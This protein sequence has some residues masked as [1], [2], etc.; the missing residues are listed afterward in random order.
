MISSLK[1][2]FKVDNL[3]YNI[4]YFNNYIKNLID[5]KVYIENIFFDSIKKIDKHNP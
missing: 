2:I 5:R 1:F 4:D 3:F